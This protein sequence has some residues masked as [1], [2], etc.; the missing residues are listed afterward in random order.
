MGFVTHMYLTSNVVVTG[1]THASMLL[2]KRRW[3]FVLPSTGGVMSWTLQ[4]SL[5]MKV[6]ALRYSQRKYPMLELSPLF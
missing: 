3:T 1:V 4:N 5:M 2:D 6:E